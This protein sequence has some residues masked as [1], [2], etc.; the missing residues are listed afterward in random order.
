MKIIPLR[1]DLL[2]YLVTHHLAKKWEKARLFFERDTTI[3]CSKWSSLSLTGVVS[4]RSASTE[5]IGRFFS[6][7]TAKRRYL[8]LPTTIRNEKPF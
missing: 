3:L 2:K 5:N 4:I 1:K 8:R 7:S 6:S